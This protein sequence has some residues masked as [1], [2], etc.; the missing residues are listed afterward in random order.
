MFRRDT[1]KVRGQ[2]KLSL[3]V[4]FVVAGPM[5][6]GL[7][8]DRQQKLLTLSQP[9]FGGVWKV[10]ASLII[11][12]LSQGKSDTDFLMY[13]HCSI[14]LM[15]SIIKPVVPLNYKCVELDLTLILL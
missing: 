8:I 3:C 10:D 4:I 7:S 6:G 12:W 2:K 15:G 1:D 11:V 14:T 13:A 5:M 9:T